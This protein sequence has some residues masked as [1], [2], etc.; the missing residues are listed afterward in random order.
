M[1][2]KIFVFIDCTVSVL[3]MGN[4]PCHDVG[5]CSGEGSATW[6]K[7][8]DSVL[9]KNVTTEDELIEQKAVKPVNK[10]FKE[11]H[12]RSVQHN[13]SPSVLSQRSTID[14]SPRVNTHL[15]GDTGVNPK[16]ARHS[17]QHRQAEIQPEIQPGSAQISWP[18]SR[19]QPS[20]RTAYSGSFV[21]NPNYAPV[22][23]VS[24]GSPPM[25]I[26]AG[27]LPLQIPAGAQPM[28][29][30]AGAQP[31]QIPAGAQPMQ[32]P[33]G[34]QPMQFPAGAQPMQ[35]PVGIQPMQYPAGVQSMPPGAPYYYQGPP[36]AN[37]PSAAFVDMRS[38]SPAGIQ[39]TPYKGGR[40]VVYPS[41][42][43]FHAPPGVPF[44]QAYAAAP[45]PQVHR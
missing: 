22:V 15:D 34:A 1:T 16:N 42:G 2:F 5:L 7:V 29:I 33:A 19:V 13:N 32:F 38:A 25:T 35:V 30:P 40:N 23:P 31:M 17:E 39:K 37:A 18:A 41:G 36:V 10:T 21:Q 12:Y 14:G 43:A 26:P 9:M 20:P 4:V 44:P 8:V 27:A 11:S 45:W 24:T 6:D 28:Q 3:A